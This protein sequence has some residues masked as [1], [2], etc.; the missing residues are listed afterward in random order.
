MVYV[1]MY[2]TLDEIQTIPITTV[3]LFPTVGFIL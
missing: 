3:C 1:I 2:V